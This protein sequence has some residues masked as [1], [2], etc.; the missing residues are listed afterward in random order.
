MKLAIAA[1]AL[2]LTGCSFHD[3]PLQFNLGNEAVQLDWN[4][5]IDITSAVVLDNVM[6]GLTSYAGSLEGSEA[7]L[8]RPLPALAQSWSVSDGGRVYRFHLRA[9]VF[10]SDGV[11][12]EARH[13]VDSW[14]RLLNPVTESA[15]AYQ[16]LEVEGAAAYSR[17]QLKDFSK[18]GVKAIDTHTLEVRLRRPVPYFLH[19]VA[20]PSTFPVRRDLIEKFGE[21]WMDPEHLVTL[22]PYRIAEWTQSERI[23]LKAYA[24]YYGPSPKIST[25][26]CRLIAEPLTAYTFY[27]NGNL[28]IIPRDLPPSFARSLKTHPDYRSGPKLAENYLLFNV[29]RA[30]FNKVE[31][32][33]AFIASMNREELAAVFEGSQTPV[34]SWIPPGLLGY[35]PELGVKGEGRDAP[36]FP[37][38][39]LS[40]RFSGSDTWNLVFQ[41]MQRRMSEKL[42][43]K[44]K[45]EQLES[46]EFQKLLGARSPADAL[47]QL[48]LL[49]WVADY[50]D[51]HN[52]MNVFTSASEN[53]YMGWK[54][55]YYDE[56]VEKAVSTAD[57][58]ARRRLYQEAQKLLLE[59]QVV[60][61][62]LFLNGHQALVRSELHGVNLNVLDKWY[63]QNVEFTDTSW[64]GFSHGMLRRL[65]GIGAARREL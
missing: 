25:V 37:K 17:G 40:I 55:K 38:K 61:M 41:S 29:N 23:V 15:N 57:E 27:E 44:A 49:G 63:F 35:S 11:E 64:R 18:V 24:G 14:E 54:N 53:N 50:P 8:L 20:S 12:L 46:K 28:D 2:L 1:L 10:W 47:P 56:L 16:L 6:E 13:F 51:P 39:P 22:G 42:G 52:F 62:P 34:T 31:N 36:L 45:L 59:D 5:A 65:R 9:G 48:M 43:V 26:I 21:Q 60:L 32:R 30:P 4:R 7:E 3:R 58:G 19:L 33:R